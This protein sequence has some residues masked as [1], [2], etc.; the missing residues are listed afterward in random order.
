MVQA[1]RQG[2]E[3]LLSWSLWSVCNYCSGQV[4]QFVSTVVPEPVIATLAHGM[5][6]KS[7]QQPLGNARMWVRTGAQFRFTVH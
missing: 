5:L 1:N 3:G 7:V 4:C 2:S 6:A